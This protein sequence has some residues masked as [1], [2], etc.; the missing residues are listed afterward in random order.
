MPSG[1]PAPERVGGPISPKIF[2]KSIFALRPTKMVDCVYVCS[3][4][5]EISPVAVA[6]AKTKRRR[7]LPRVRSDSAPAVQ[8]RRSE[9]RGHAADEK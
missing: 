3:S 9:E 4:R 7:R 2:A 1:N 5:A 8:R 6:V